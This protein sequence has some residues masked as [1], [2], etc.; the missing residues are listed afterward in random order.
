[1]C[2]RVCAGVWVSLCLCV[3]VSLCLCVSVSLCLCVATLKPK[4][5]LSA[6]GF[7]EYVGTKQTVMG[8]NSHH[9]L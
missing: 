2:V 9:V 8:P 4:Q 1:V 7:P 6:Q 3:S 5:E